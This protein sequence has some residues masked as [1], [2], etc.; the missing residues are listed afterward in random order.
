M[1]KNPSLG[2]E[3]VRNLLALED[4]FLFEIYELKHGD[5]V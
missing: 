2:G 5:E 4:F 3:Q 1:T